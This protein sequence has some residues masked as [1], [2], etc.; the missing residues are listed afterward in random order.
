MDEDDIVKQKSD[1]DIQ[2]NNN[3][4]NSS[5]FIQMPL[6]GIDQ[7]DDFRKK[8]YNVVTNDRFQTI[9]IGMIIVNSILMGV[10]TYLPN[11]GT[12]EFDTASDREQRAVEA[13]ANID[14][15][16]L[17]LFTVELCM[18]IFVFLHTTLTDKW[19]LFDA[20]TIIFSWA[21]SGFTIM[22]SFRIFRVFRLF[23]RI[24]SLKRIVAAVA[25]TS[26]G[27]ASI[28]LVLFI[29]FYVFAVM[30]TQLF[31]DCWA[32]CC[33]AQD[34]VLCEKAALDG[35]KPNS[36]IN[37]VNFY[38][39]LDYTFFTLFLLM[40]FDDFYNIIA[41]TEYEYS[42]ASYPL[43]LFMLISGL[44]ML[45]LIV[46]VLC[47]ALN[48]L[49]SQDEEDASVM[50]ENFKYYI[51]GEIVF[52]NT[53]MSREKIEKYFFDCYEEKEFYKQKDKENEKLL[54]RIENQFESLQQ[55]M[56][57]SWGHHFNTKIAS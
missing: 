2:D 19:L 47:E 10:N 49:N 32:E 53:S 4:N 27:L 25:S 29:L 41:M 39:R 36:E 7:F 38:G 12:E 16:F 13:I 22:R 14:F 34:Q 44:V 56:S 54:V 48:T 9:V 8:M 35:I 3:D 21:F 42:W 6:T 33:F 26:E 24:E 40:T 46:A 1:A 55:T 45:N 51:N 28:V 15:I 50:M 31:K 11:L 20:T 37:G 57:K 43:V 17:I 18:N 30:F 52:V 23:G 5:D